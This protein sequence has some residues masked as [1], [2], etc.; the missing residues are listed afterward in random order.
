MK[1]TTRRWM[2]SLTAMVL[3]VGK[4]GAGTYTW[5]NDGAA[6]LNDGGGSWAA[7]GGQN[8]FDGTST[9]G[10]WGNT[11]SD[12][13]VFGVNNGAAGSIAVGTVTANGITFNAPGS[14]NYTLTN[15]TIT[16]GGASPTITANVDATIGSCL[17][18]SVGLIKSGAGTLTLSGANTYTGNTTNNGGTLKVTGKIHSYH[19]STAVVT[20]QNGGVLELVTWIYGG[21]LGGISDS[22]NQVVVN[23]GTIRMTGTTAYG[24]GVILNGPATLE[25]AAGA[26]WTI[27]PGYNWTY[28]N[29][30]MV[31]T[32]A[33]TG[34]FKR[35]ISGNGS[36]TKS[37]AGTWTLNATNTY[38]GGTAVDVGMLQFA[39]TNSMPASGT[40]TVTGASLAVNVGGPGEWGTGTSGAGT[41]GGLLGGTGGQGSPVAYSGDITLG[42]DTTN[43]VGTQ[44]YP[45]AIT[46][47]G[48]SLA[49]TKLG[50]GTL[51]LSGTNTY[52][53]GT[54]I[55]AGMLKLTSTGSI[56]N[57]PVINV[58]SGAVFDVSA[59]TPYTI[60]ASQ[61][62][63]GSGSVTGSVTLAA[64]ATLECNYNTAAANVLNI[65]GTLTLPASLTLNVNG[66]GPLPSSV[67]LFSAGT[68]AGATDLSGWTV[69]CSAKHAATRLIVSNNQVKMV[70]LRMRMGDLVL[71]YDRPAQRWSEEALPIG[72]GYMGAMIFGGLD[73]ERIQFNEGSL[74]VGDEQD[75]GSY[76]AF[77]DVFV[78]LQDN[79]AKKQ[80]LPEKADARDVARYQYRR[81]LD[82]SR[83][84]HTVTYEKDGVKYR[85]ESFASY[86][87]R[88]MAFRFTA[89]KPGAL[90]GTVM[91]TDMHQAK[92]SIDQNRFTATGSLAGCGPEWRQKKNDPYKI[93][94]S[95]E[96]QLA[97]RSD[98]GTVESREGRIVFKNANSVTLILS[99]ATDFVQDHAKG[100]KGEHPHAAL[101]ARIDAALKRSWDALLSE[102]VRDYQSLF[103]R[104]S[105]DLG[106]TTNSDLMTDVRVKALAKEAGC[107]P[108]LEQ[109]LFQHGRYLMI[110]SS[111]PGS[112]PANLQGKWNDSNTPMWRCDYHANI[113]VQMNYWPVEVGNLSECFEPF[114]SWIDS[115]REVRTAAFRKE[116][117]F[118]GWAIR[119]EN[120]PFGGSTYVWQVGAAS[121]LLQNSY[122]HYRFTGDK[123]YLRKYAYPAM[124]EVCDYWIDSLIPQPDGTLLTPMGWSPEQGPSD[125]GI[126]FDQQ[127]AWDLFTSTIEAS[128][129]LGVDAG[130]RAQLTELKKKLPEPKIGSWGQVLE[131]RT[132]QTNYQGDAARCGKLDTPENKHRHLSHLVALFPGRQISIQK[133]PALAE[134]A[135]VTMNARGDVS[136]GWSTA[137]KINLWARLQDGDRAYRLIN[138]LLKCRIMPNLFDTHPPFQIDG[139]FGYTAG[140]CEMLIQSHFDEIH[141]LPALP[142]AWPSGSVK[143][144]RARGGFTVDIEWTKGRVT[145]YH[146][147]SAEPKEVKVRINGE[148]KTVKSEKK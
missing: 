31:L 97:V 36:L 80:D 88:V 118:R 133:T 132:E 135:R 64:N 62:L 94:L 110:A 40:V 89:D 2:A 7:T 144:L 124:K 59:K 49:I 79:A 93:A 104:V 48:A 78:D 45:G 91:L 10:A 141:L 137:N 111:R 58:V 39:T 129:A 70:T 77:G 65:T 5:D 8:W 100:W 25:S 1:R 43:A 53:G 73:Q 3:V 143:G 41:I 23:N 57:S 56:S 87:A 30:S 126:A 138:F 84:I 125:I 42:F 136:T 105:L 61:T 82:I 44:T 15:G 50:V 17:T 37:G 4:A 95:Y 145:R 19:T 34:A 109:L 83:A 52:S 11:V 119:A 134:A 146:I 113:N 140:V 18:G 26:N 66:S 96:S 12:I 99:A 117:K 148:V 9:Y 35:P 127:M 47:V 112:L 122:D 75:T 116:S 16:L 98:G 147:T 60:L 120:G 74:W 63:K 103:N 55:N 106:E 72:N 101:S 107:D 115:I 90:N 86:P 69:N 46:N 29:N 27:T 142:K 32:G 14:G 128:E 85:R 6:P 131:W 13:A 139:N 76:Q 28:N 67:V 20:V 81:E 121:W 114:A 33:G 51:A 21:S 102:H 24:R 123:E 92:I 71:R 108:G 54:V 130:L 22:A 68:L 38:G